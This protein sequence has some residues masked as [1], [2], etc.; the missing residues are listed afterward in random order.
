SA[1]VFARI[2]FSRR[3][4]T[5]ASAW[6]RSSRGICPASTR[7]RFSRA[8]SWASS[9]DRCWTVTLAKVALNVQYACLTAAIVWTAASR[10]WRSELFSFR[11]A[12][13]YCCRASS[14]ERSLRSGCENASTRPDCRLGSK[15]LIG[16]LVAVRELSH[17]TLQVP[18]PTGRRCRTPVDENKSSTLTPRS[19]SRKFDGGVAVLDRPS[20][21]E[22]I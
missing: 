7:T 17:E 11:F 5:S 13:T 18:E 1:P 12:M 19:P 21:V 2:R 6:T 4:D 9:N 3:W 20:I 14:I 16:L 10:K 22:N 8:S 15:L